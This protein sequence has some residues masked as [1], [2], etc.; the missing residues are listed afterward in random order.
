M[1]SQSHIINPETAQSQYV[2]APAG[3]VSTTSTGKRPAPSSDTPVRV[4]KKRNCSEHFENLMRYTV[5]PGTGVGKRAMEAA[6]RAFKAADQ[7]IIR[8]KTEIA[9]LKKQVHSK[10]KASKCIVNYEATSGSVRSLKRAHINFKPIAIAADDYFKDLIY[11]QKELDL[12][13]LNK[14]VRNAGEEV[15]KVHTVLGASTHTQQNTAME[16]R[17]ERFNIG[18]TYV[19]NARYRISKDSQTLPSIFY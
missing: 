4:R 3:S 9:D 10:K 14:V 6:Q 5:V 15:V 18:H 1:S 17:S 12:S 13:E 19:G 16:V 2:E 7:R 8:L 11:Y